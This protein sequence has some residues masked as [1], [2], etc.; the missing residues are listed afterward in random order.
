MILRLPWKAAS[1]SGVSL[2]LP[3]GVLGCAPARSTT[4]TTP[5]KP[6]PQASN[7][8][9]RPAKSFVL[10]SAPASASRWTLSACPLL[11]ATWSGVSPFS[12]TSFRFA[13]TISRF[14]R[15]EKRRCAVAGDGEGAGGGG[16]RRGG[17]VR[18]GGGSFALE[19]QG[20]AASPEEAAA[21][22][23]SERR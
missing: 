4:A 9:E 11:A 22:S 13:L 7:S 1:W 19:V 18:G 12:L 8:G 5:S 6:R 3:Q 14:R 21:A 16:V 2:S 20:E 15:A 17:G 23:S 10:V